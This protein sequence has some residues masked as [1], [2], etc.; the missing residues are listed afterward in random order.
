MHYKVYL[1][2]GRENGTHDPHKDSNNFKTT[3]VIDNSQCSKSV[4]VDT[5]GKN[6][7]RSIEHT[8]T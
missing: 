2:L 3:H 7:D 4:H 6:T 1:C 5:Q 8:S